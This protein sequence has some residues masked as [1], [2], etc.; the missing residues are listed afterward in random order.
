MLSV[1]DKIINIDQFSYILKILWWINFQYRHQPKHHSHRSLDRLQR[2]SNLESNNENSFKT[3]VQVISPDCQHMVRNGYNLE[4]WLECKIWMN[5]LYLILSQIRVEVDPEI[6]W[7][8]VWDWA[9]TYIVENVFK[10]KYLRNNK[11]EYVAHNEL[12]RGKKSILTGQCTV[13]P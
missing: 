7:N 5:F 10:N 9:D 4:K 3:R 8:D 6:G 12:K 2:E 11:M 1:L 13:L